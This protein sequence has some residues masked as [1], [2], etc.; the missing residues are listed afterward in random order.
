MLAGA[1]IL[2]EPVLNSI[3]ILWAALF[4]ST[5]AALALA[6]EPPS[7]SLLDRK[8]ATKFDKIVNAVMWRNIFGQSIYQIAVLLTLLFCGKDWFGFTYTDDT[9]LITTQKWLNSNPDSGYTENEMT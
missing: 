9:P 5:F 6:T 8:P 7:K 2:S 3:Q 4:L 1:V